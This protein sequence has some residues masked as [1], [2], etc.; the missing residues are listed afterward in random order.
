MASKR[1][2]DGGQEL[3]HMRARG[4]NCP[5]LLLHRLRQRRVWRSLGRLLYG[6]H[7]WRFMSS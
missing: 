3:E 1:L 5:P 4:L 6:P 7:A 2:Q